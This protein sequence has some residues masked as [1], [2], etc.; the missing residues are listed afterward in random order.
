MVSLAADRLRQYRYWS[1]YNSPYDAHDR[2]CAIDLYPA[3]PTAPSPVAGEVLDTRTV[4]APPKAYAAEHDHLILVDCGDVVARI[5]HV[6]PVVAPGEHVAVGD[7]LGDLV[8]AGFFAPWVENHLH[9][10][11]RDPADNLYRASGS[12]RIE[13]G[14]EVRPLDWDGTGT[15][16]HAGD[17]Y[18]VLDAPTHPHPG[19][20]WVGIAGED[21]AGTA[22]PVDG[23]L[24]HYD[25]GG[26][27]G[28]TDGPLTLLGTE[29]GVVDDR[30]VDWQ[31]VTVRANGHAVT[32]LSLFVGGTAD[33]G[34][35]VI[36]P[37]LDLPVGEDV[38][39]RIERE[40]DD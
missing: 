25:G 20:A 7:A 34:A 36:C 11:F 35:K 40:D 13:P 12:L 24:P 4:R 1:A 33:F 32:G 27:Y 31:D 29:V 9:L 23:G 28:A 5:L 16:A 10:G 6:E 14:V 30:T 8:R 17:T 19:E 38:R 22:V 26:A 18:A 3:G 2:G 37:D 21:A 15:V 39:V